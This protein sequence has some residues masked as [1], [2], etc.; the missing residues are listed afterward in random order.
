MTK[1]Q[2]NIRRAFQIINIY[3]ICAE[4]ADEALHSIL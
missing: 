1:V 2:N 4:E 3:A